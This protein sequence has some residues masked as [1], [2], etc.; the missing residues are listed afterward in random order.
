MKKHGLLLITLV[1]TFTNAF[2]QII[3][4]EIMTFCSAIAG[5]DPNK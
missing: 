5:R 4:S 2:S 3:N 1:M